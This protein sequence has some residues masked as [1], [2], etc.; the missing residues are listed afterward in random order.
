M[1][2]AKGIPE[3]PFPP[4][5]IMPMG[6]ACHRLPSNG[7]PYSRGAQ[8]VH[9]AKF[10]W[11]MNAGN[12]SV[13]RD[14]TS[15]CN[16][17]QKTN[18]LSSICIPGL[19]FHVWFCNATWLQWNGLNILLKSNPGHIEQI[20]LSCVYTSTSVFRDRA[21]KN[22]SSKTDHCRD[23]FKLWIFFLKKIILGHCLDSSTTYQNIFYCT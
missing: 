8:T 16:A 10:Q 9:K 12:S 14:S 1:S 18:H 22:S 11:E 5:A 2:R 20:L 15:S 23:H 4:A 13:F 7:D 3:A 17:K 6:K 19:N 21:I